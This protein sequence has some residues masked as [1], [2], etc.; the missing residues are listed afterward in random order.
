MWATLVHH[1][2]LTVDLSLARSAAVLH[3]FLRH[4]TSPHVCDIDAA[5][6]WLAQRADCT[7]SIGV[8]GYC[9]GGGLALLLAPDRGFAALSELRA[10]AADSPRGSQLHGADQEVSLRLRSLRLG[11]DG[12]LTALT[13][14]LAAYRHPSLL[15]ALD[16]IRCSLER[17]EPDASDPGR[18]VGEAPSVL[19]RLT[20]SA[21]TG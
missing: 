2:S 17:Y 16:L 5:R 9:L 1:L 12:V 13:P 21:N 10:T 4:G 7:G 3:A 11:L 18:S 6:E 19:S 14:T 15:R 20:A 8:I